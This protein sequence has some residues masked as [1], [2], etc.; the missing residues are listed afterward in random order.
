MLKEITADA[1]TEYQLW[2][3]QM[4][5]RS[6][7]SSMIIDHITFEDRQGNIYKRDYLDTSTMEA[8]N[9]IHDRVE[10][11]ILVPEMV[12]IIL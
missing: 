7:D 10:D 3:K 1:Y 11:I 12:N 2:Y 6:I 9:V 5:E 4:A 8:Y